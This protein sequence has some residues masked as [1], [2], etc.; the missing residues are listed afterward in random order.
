MS[1][2]RRL[3][4]WLLLALV[5]VVGLG[6]AVLGTALAPKNA[7]LEKAVSN[8][9]AAPSYTQIV[10]EKTTQ[11]SESY[12]L[13]WQAPNRLGGYVQSGNR[14]TYVYVLPSAKGPME[15]QSVTVAADASTEHLT[16]YRQP[17]QSA[18]SVDPTKIYLHYAVGAKGVTSSGNTYTFT[19]TQ[20]GST[21]TPETGTFVYTVNGPY[22][23]QFNLTVANESVQLVISD[24]GSSPPV[25]LPA[26]A[27]I[28]PLPTTTSPGT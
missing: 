3:I 4:S 15:Y 22:I 17:I 10:T 5:A 13:V 6:G 19:L 20:T 24:V 2:L 12:F 27:K 9:L 8:T 26:G 16:F 28:L 23:S 25:R 1:D 11:G 7:P 21:G 18:A 14:R